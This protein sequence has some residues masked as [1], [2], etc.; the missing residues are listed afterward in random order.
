MVKRDGSLK[1]DVIKRETLRALVKES[2]E[3]KK[4]YQQ[5]REKE[6]SKATETSLST[7]NISG[8]SCSKG[9]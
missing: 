6:E 7:D 1:D 4:E 3:N 5:R 2:E 8:P 9:G